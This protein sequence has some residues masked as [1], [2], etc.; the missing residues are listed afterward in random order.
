MKKL[1]LFLIFI[2]TLD[3]SAQVTRASL[4]EWVSAQIIK[5]RTGVTSVIPSATNAVGLGSTDFIWST[6]VSGTWTLGDD[7]DNVSGQLN[8]IASDNDQANI[9]I[10]T[11]D[12]ITFNSAGG[13]YLF[14]G[15]GIFNNNANALQLGDDASDVD[16]VLNFK[17][18]TADGSIT[19]MEDEDRFDFDNHV[20]VGGDLTVSGNLLVTGSETYYAE[21]YFN[22]NSSAQ[23]PTANDTTGIIY[24]TQGDLNGFTFDAGSSG[25][26][27]E[28][29]DGGGGTI[30]ILD[31]EHGLSVGDWIMITN[32]SVAGYEGVHVVT[33][34]AT[35]TFKVAVAYSAT[36]T[37]DWQE[38]SRVTLTQ[39]GLT[40][41]K[42]KVDWNISGSVA[43]S[44]A[45]D[46]VVWG[47]YVNEIPKVEAHQI[48]TLSTG[49]VYGS[50]GSGAIINMSTN[51]DLFMF[52]VSDD[53][54]ALTHKYG[55]VRLLKL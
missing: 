39:A 22:N 14:D 25:S 50:F 43:G 1:I 26:Y 53:T 35:D 32:S 46:A 7:S 24:F 20:K 16:V 49:G 19:F 15:V 48:R 4:W 10:N 2:F 29:A 44:P 6:G 34:V 54:N 5:S 47:V 31:A 51:D 11:S 52:F 55:S 3:L 21:M 12:Q 17:A 40:N 33:Y 30:A 41:A 27:T 8:F 13:G 28:V 37:G 45:G 38:P 18:N 42:F 9:A 23:T 36:A